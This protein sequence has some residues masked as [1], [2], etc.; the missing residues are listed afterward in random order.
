MTAEPTHS[1]A[2]VAGV[3]CL[4]WVVSISLVYVNKYLVTSDA[5]PLFITWFQCLITCVICWFCGWMGHRAKAKDGLQS[6]QKSIFSTFPRAQYDPLT[7]WNVM[8]LSFIFVAMIVFNQLTLKYVAVSFYNVARSLTIVFNALFSYIILRTTVSLPTILCLMIVITGFFVGSAGEVEFSRLGS[9]CG[10]LASVFVSL[11]SI[12]TKRILPYVNNDA[13]R[14]AFIN[15]ANACFLFLPFIYFYEREIL[16]DVRSHYKSI[17][18]IPF[19]GSMIVAGF[20]GF[21]IGIVTVMQAI[22]SPLTHNISGTAKAAVQSAMA[23][24]I[25]GNPATIMACLG[26]FLV[27]SGSA[28]Y[29]KVKLWENKKGPIPLPR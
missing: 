19:W 29:T 24:Y 18:T 23:F 27:L 12:F 26:I 13:W 4:Y 21:S 25:W 1:K 6:A 9:V 3:V 15:N 16:I 2:Y 22:T 10:V 11:N 14:L 17:F 8:P 7:V 28:L 20:L 5:I